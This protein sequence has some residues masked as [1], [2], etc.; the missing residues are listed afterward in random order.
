MDAYQNQIYTTILTR[1][2]I[3]NFDNERIVETEKI[4]SLMKAAMA[5]P[6]ACNIQPWEFII[7]TKMEI[8]KSI[9]DSITQYGDYNTNVIIV[10]CGNNEHIPWKDYGILDCAMAMENIMILAP[11]LG[12]GSVCIGGFDRE[13]VAQILHIPDPIKPIGMLYVGYPKEVKIPRTK[14]LESAIHWNIFDESRKR[15]PRPGNIIEFGP[16]ASL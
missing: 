10:V 4:E 3:R 11:A 14:Y 16:E 5:A 1:R 9:K 15:E 7:I 2:S 13:K 6:S 8:I 12:L